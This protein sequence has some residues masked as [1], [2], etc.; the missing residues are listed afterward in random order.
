MEDPSELLT[1]TRDIGTGMSTLFL[2]ARPSF[3]IYDGSK[4]F[5][6][7]FLY[8]LLKADVLQDYILR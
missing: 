2:I 3:R 1:E 5:L 4:G 6:F 8:H 7:S